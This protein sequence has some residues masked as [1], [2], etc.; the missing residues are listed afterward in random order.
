MLDEPRGAS[1]VD[2]ALASSPWSWPSWA[3]AEPAQRPRASTAAG[4]A[5]DNRIVMGD[6]P[7]RWD[8]R[9]CHRQAASCAWVGAR[10]LRRRVWGARGGLPPRRSGER[11]RAPSRRG[12]R[13]AGRQRTPSP[14][15]A[16]TKTWAQQQPGTGRGNPPGRP[17]VSPPCRP[18]LRRPMSRRYVVPRRRGRPD[19]G[20]PIRREPAW[21]CP[22]WAWAKAG[23]MTRRATTRRIAA[24]RRSRGRALRIT[25]NAY[26]ILGTGTVGRRARRQ[27]PTIR[28]PCART[29]NALRDS[30]LACS[31]PERRQGVRS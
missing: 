2:A 11:G 31:A 15:D 22:A 7:S 5:A 20:A 28:G 3:L 8:G 1:A 21:S 14:S 12:D 16:A 10:S 9:G 17:V 24:S 4:R 18:M 26:H 23:T 6:E 29:A 13:S 27:T 25:G 19:G 30:G